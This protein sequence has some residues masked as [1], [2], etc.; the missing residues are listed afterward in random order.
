MAPRASLAAIIF[1]VP[2]VA[3]LG[4]LSAAS[5]IAVFTTLSSSDIVA[6]AEAQVP[7]PADQAQAAA[8]ANIHAAALF[9]GSRYRL[10]AART[11]LALPAPLRVSERP[12]IERLTRT[13]LAAAPMS[14]Y[15]W[16]LLSFLQFERG[17]VAGA[18]R[19]WEMSVLVGRYVPNLMQSRLLLG[20]R[21][22]R[23][24]RSLANSVTDQVRVLAEGDPS[25]LAQAARHGGVEAPVRAILAGSEQS[26]AFE[27][28]TKAL[29]A[30]AQARLKRQAGAKP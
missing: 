13:S 4:W 29:V 18:T 26:V 19:A 27:K 12:L 30:G 21:M 11:L 22:L 20:M 6:S 8:A 28:A 14:S 15:G 25:S 10:H 24:D 5:A 3:L 2:F 1:L 9:E 16:T 23:Y 7:I 17:D